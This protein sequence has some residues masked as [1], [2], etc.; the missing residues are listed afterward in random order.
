VQ[1]VH[2]CLVYLS[3]ILSRE[4]PK[5]GSGEQWKFLRVNCGRKTLLW[6]ILNRGED[7]PVTNYATRM[8]TPMLCNL[9]AL[10]V[11]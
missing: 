11:K 3:S 8:L 2:S 7:L 1:F 4:L 10:I 5:V 6:P 9:A